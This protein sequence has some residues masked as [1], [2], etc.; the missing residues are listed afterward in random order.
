MNNELVILNDSEVPVP[1]SALQIGTPHKSK[2]FTKNRK[3]QI[4]LNRKAEDK[5]I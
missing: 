4:K 5:R 2:T 3:K 1:P